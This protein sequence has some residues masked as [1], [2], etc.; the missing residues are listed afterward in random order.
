MW[1]REKVGNVPSYYLREGTEKIHKNFQSTYSHV[2]NKHLC[3]E[4]HT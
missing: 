1:N 3:G 2:P 4:S